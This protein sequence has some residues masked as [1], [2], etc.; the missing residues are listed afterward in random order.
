[1][2][3]RNQVERVT[4]DVQILQRVNSGQLILVGAFNELSFGVVD[5]LFVQG[6]MPDP[7][8]KPAHGVQT[9]FNPIIKELVYA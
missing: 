1:M 6:S 7:D 3:V 9:R 8:M 5:F 2:N 4:P